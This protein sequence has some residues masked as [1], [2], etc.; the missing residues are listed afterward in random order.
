MKSSC[1]LSAAKAVCDHLRDWYVG[2]E[3]GTITSMGVISDGSYNI[4][5]GCVC[6]MP[7]YCKENF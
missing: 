6:S 3:K 1:V 7:V 4:P 2:T 5:K